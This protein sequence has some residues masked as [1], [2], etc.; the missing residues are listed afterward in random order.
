MVPSELLIAAT[1]TS[2]SALGVRPCGVT[3]VVPEVF[4]VLYIISSATAQLHTLYTMKTHYMLQSLLAHQCHY[5][6]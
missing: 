4:T 6:L 5:Q 2:Y 1:S 3:L